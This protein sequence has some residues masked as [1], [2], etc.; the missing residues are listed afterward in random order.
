[1]LGGGGMTFLTAVRVFRSVDDELTDPSILP[2][3]KIYNIS[4]NRHYYSPQLENLSS[5]PDYSLSTFLFIPRR[6]N[7]H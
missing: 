1:M 5:T 7:S 4:T 6:N 2:V 3:T